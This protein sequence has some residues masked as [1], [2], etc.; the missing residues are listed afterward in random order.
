MAP[1]IPGYTAVISEEPEEVMAPAP[2]PSEEVE[3]PVL[4]AKFPGREYK[5]ALSGA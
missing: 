3:A 5:L 2:A 1:T 4:P